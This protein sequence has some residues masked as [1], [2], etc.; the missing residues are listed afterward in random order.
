M[1][2]PSPKEI[3]REAREALARSKDTPQDRW[4]RMIRMGFI[5]EKGEVTT[6]LGGDV[7]PEPYAEIEGEPNGVKTVP[8]NG[9]A[10]PTKRRKRKSS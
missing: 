8:K 4:D 1:Y 3:A 2:S 7:P 10:K 5:N 6:L 9:K